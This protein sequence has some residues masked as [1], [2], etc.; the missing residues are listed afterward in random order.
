MVIIEE[1]SKM[2]VEAALV[3]HDHV[4]EAFAP[5]VPITRSTY[6]RCHGEHGT[7]KTCLI[8]LGQNIHAAWA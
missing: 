2:S 7:D 8:P 1:A 5:I 6:A 3:K 4:I